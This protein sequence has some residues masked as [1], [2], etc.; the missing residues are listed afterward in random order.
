[1][2]R[3]QPLYLNRGRENVVLVVPEQVAAKEV[4]ELLH[5]VECE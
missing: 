1:M 2:D 4:D 5:D 3:Y